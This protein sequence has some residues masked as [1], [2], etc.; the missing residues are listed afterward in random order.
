MRTYVCVSVCS[1]HTRTQFLSSLLHGRLTAGSRGRFSS[2]LDFLLLRTQ[3]DELYLYN[4]A[5]I[6][7]CWQLPLRT[8]YLG[9]VIM[10]LA[11]SSLIASVL[12]ASLWERCV[13]MH[14]VVGDGII[15]FVHFARPLLKQLRALH[16][17]RVLHSAPAGIF[18]LFGSR[19]DVTRTNSSTPPTSLAFALP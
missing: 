2:L 6:L 11:S 9:L 18:V 8:F 7:C 5:F 12:A 10:F 17:C 16:A 3:S 4:I 19:Y 15:R 14:A 1:T 13:D